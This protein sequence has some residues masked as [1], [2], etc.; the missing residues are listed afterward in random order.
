[1]SN[2]YEELLLYNLQCVSFPICEVVYRVNSQRKN[3][4]TC[5]FNIL[6]TNYS[7]ISECLFLSILVIC[8]H[9]DSLA[10]KTDEK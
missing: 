4:C 9:I 7:N 6:L 3:W 10:S 8:Y 2:Y 5:N 1:M